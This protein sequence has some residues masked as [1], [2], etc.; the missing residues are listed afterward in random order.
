MADPIITTERLI[1]RRFEAS[2]HDAYHAIFAH[3]EVERWLLPVASREESFRH[4]AMLEGFWHLRGT[5]MMA[6]ERREDGKLIGRCGPW[7]PPLA[8]GREIEVG[9]T[10]APEE[11]RRGYAAEAARASMAWAFERF[12][13]ARIVHMIDDENTASQGVARKIGS[14]PTDET[15]THHIAGEIRLWAQEAS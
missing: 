14:T 2:D 3:P 10:I 8:E 9:W 5:S 7:H 6:V 12:A 4:M 15:V 1:L 13:P 11:Q